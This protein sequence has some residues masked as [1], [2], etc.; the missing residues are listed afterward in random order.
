M[1]FY[2]ICVTFSLLG[3]FL[4]P[5]FGGKKEIFGGYAMRD[6]VVNLGLFLMFWES[7]SCGFRDC[8]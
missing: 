5:F 7:F 4:F 3:A 2:L 8:L 1:A 6:I